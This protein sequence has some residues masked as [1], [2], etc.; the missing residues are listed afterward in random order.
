MKVSATWRSGIPAL[1]RRFTPAEARGL[2]AAAN[3]VRTA[4][5]ERL[6]RGYTSNE[7]NTRVIAES[8]A[9]R[10]G[11]RGQIRVQTSSVAALGW[12]LGHFN[13]FLRR[14][15]RVEIW[16]PAL[17]A[18]RLDQVRAYAAAVRQTAQV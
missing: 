6:T 5:H 16:R 12:E 10:P 11:T 4:V 1:L 14:F 13:I 8:V 7:F 18:T 15:V 17:N 9:I 3:V 2:E